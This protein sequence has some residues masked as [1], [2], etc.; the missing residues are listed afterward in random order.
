[1]TV[2]TS[3]YGPL[4]RWESIAGLNADLQYDYRRKQ[5]PV[6]SHGFSEKT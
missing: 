2:L 1:M 4:F 5:Q 3:F 6:D